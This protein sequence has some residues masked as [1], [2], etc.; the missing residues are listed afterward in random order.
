MD[1]LDD[2]QMGGDPEGDGV[3]IPSPRSAAYGERVRVRGGY[4]SLTAGLGA[5]GS[6]A[7]VQED[8]DARPP[9][10]VIDP[11]PK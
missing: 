3:G 7:D 2:A 6:R 11:K 5:I 9:D 10:D 1:R 4:S 8:L